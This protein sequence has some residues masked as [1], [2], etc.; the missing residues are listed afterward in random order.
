MLANMETTV[1]K[2]KNQLSSLLRAAE[3]GEEVVIRKGRNGPAFRL[4]PVRGG[5][6]R[7]LA[8]DPRWKGAVRYT[9]EDIWA[10]E[11]EPE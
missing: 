7:T 11:W 3:R 1:L 9:D 8:P 10:S 2:A 5:G 6:K 4:V